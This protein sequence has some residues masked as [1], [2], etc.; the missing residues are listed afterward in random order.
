MPVPT[1]RLQQIK[2]Y[3]FATL[4]EKKRARLATGAT[5]VDLSLGSPDQPTPQPIVD[6]L[7]AAVQDRSR[8][9]YPDFS[10]D[11]TFKRSF[12]AFLGRRFGATVD[13][14]TQLVPTAGAKEALAQV[15]QTYCNAGD[16]VLITDVAYPVYER[17]AMAVGAETV[18]LPVSAD[19]GWWPDLGAVSAE[20]RRRTKVLVLNFPNNPTGAVTTLARLAAAVEFAR[21]ND[22][23]LVSDLAYSELTFRGD[24]APSVLQ[25]PG[26]LATAIEIHSGSKN[27]SMAGLRVGM[28]VGNPEVCRALNVCRSLVGYGAPTVIQLAA[29]KA[30]ERAEELSSLL[31]AGYRARFEA[32]GTGFADGGFPVELPAAAMYL[33]LPVPAGMTDWEATELLLAR[34][35]IV[36]TPGSGFGAGGAGYLR[37]SMVA[38]PAV[39]EDA[40]RRAASLWR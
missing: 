7:V 18:A 37:M 16:V 22:I 19:D 13:P 10:G 12:A 29:A 31:R 11:V 6:A 9:G 33:W 1:E 8:D 32:A 23:L 30:F 20:L 40:A 5:I 15:I 35:G 26:A 28:V 3:V 34:E 4:A 39:L 14:M 25:V 21:A 17:A 36:L 24:P 2:P 27:F 38:P